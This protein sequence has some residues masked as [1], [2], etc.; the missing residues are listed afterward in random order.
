[1]SSR[2]AAAA[3]RRQAASPAPTSRKG[4][5]SDEEKIAD[6]LKRFAT[7]VADLDDP[8]LPPSLVESQGWTVK[9]PAGEQ[10]TSRGGHL[11]SPRT[12][13]RCSSYAEAVAEMILIRDSPPPRPP[14]S[15]S[16]VA[17]LRTVWGL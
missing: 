12:Q 6:K 5:K 4:G 13:S 1:M 7:H 11:M 14:P 15:D 16:E 2:R 9:L 3:A 8:D 17:W 10:Y